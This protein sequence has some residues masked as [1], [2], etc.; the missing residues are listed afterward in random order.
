MLLLLLPSL[1]VVDTKLITE[2]EREVL[3]M[4]TQ[5]AA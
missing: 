2:E 3:G 1:S 5:V 4:L